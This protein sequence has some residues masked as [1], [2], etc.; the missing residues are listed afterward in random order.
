MVQANI[1][2][3]AEMRRRAWA[4]IRQADILFSF[5]VGLPSMTKISNYEPSLPRN[6]YDDDS[7]NEGCKGIPFPLPNTEPTEISYVIAKTR[8]AF[9][10][11]Q[12]LQELEPRELVSYERVLEID[13]NLREEYAN[14]PLMYKLGDMSEQ[15]EDP[16]PLIFSRFTMASLHHKSLCVLHSRYLEKARTNEQYLYSRRICLESAMSIL[17]LQAVQHY[18]FSPEG[19]LRSLIKYQT[20]L[21]IHDYLLAATILSA[22]LYLGKPD[23]TNTSRSTRSSLS[24]PSWIDM[25]TSLDRCANAFSQ[26]RDKSIEAYKASDVLGML[27]R[28]FQASTNPRRFTVYKGLEPYSK[29]AKA[30][31]SSENELDRQMTGRHTQWS[32]HDASKSNYGL[33][34]LRPRRNSVTVIE[35]STQNSRMGAMQLTRDAPL[36]TQST[37]DFASRPDRHVLFQESDSH[38]Q[39]ENSIDS[40]FD[41]P[42][43]SNFADPENECGNFSNNIN[44]TD[45]N[46]SEGTSSWYYSLLD[47]SDPVSTLWNLN[48]D[49]NHKAY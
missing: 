33:E 23:D 40:H 4:F 14:V 36:A 19:K 10:F 46:M 25:L 29:G 11:A 35:A 44:P 49:N 38:G 15:T 48:S 42:S 9:G 27:L 8:L 2:L 16:L 13:R 43:Q 28:K 47:L 30:F 32:S 39:V 3:K 45:D 7:F 12:A 37:L 31:Q 20:S 17:R 1:I 26:M 5:Q 34:W 6:F 22:E 24:A 18:D 41:Y 21:S